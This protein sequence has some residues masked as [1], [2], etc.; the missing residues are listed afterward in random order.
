MVIANIR[1]SV[2][3]ER[4]NNEMGAT[5]NKK[6]EFNYDTLSEKHRHKLCY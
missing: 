2:K 5:M 3:V 6:N 4:E 1:N